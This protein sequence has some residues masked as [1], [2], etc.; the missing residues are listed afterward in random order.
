MRDQPEQP[1]RAGR[2]ARRRPNREAPVCPEQFWVSFD[3][4][5]ELIGTSRRRVRLLAVSGHLTFAGRA[6]GTR[7]V[8]AESIEA[9]REW[10]SR[11]GRVRRFLAR[12]RNF[13]RVDLALFS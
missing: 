2:R 5:A 11:H 3:T 7:G 13:P 12:R 8:T 10:R 6:D 1:A 4:A 9:E